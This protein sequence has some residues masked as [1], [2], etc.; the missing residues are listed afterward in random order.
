MKTICPSSSYARILGIGIATLDIINSVAEYPVEDSE[1]RALAQRICRGGNATNT[2]TVLS[3]LGHACAWAGVWVDEPHGHLIRSEL[4]AARIDMRYCRVVT[5]GCMPVS[6]ITLNRSN[7]SRTIVHYRDLPEFSR[8]DFDRIEC[9]AY[10]WLHF[11]GR[12]INDTLY[13][14]QQARLWPVRISLEVEKM[15]PG[16]EALYPYADV[17]LFSKQFVL[18][19]HTTPQEFVISMATQFPTA[20]ILCAWGAHGAYACSAGTRIL[21]HCPALPP[22]QILD[23]I[24]AGDT[25]NAA[26]IH[27]LAQGMTLEQAVP[28]ACSLAG[29]KCGRIGLV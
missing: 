1:V 26:I 5:Q 4:E 6:Y 10:D 28:L 14:L 11:E 20:H 21:F 25:F 19:Q 23:T 7:G 8:A 17:L 3:H 22:P 24:G 18:Q 29:E 12:N 2:L 27:A 9:S 15:R 13:M 16:I